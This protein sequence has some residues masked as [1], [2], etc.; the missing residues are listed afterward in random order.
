MRKLSIAVLFALMFAGALV[1][2]DA[3][4]SLVWNDAEG[5]QSVVTVDTYVDLQI[6][7]E[8]IDSVPV[9]QD[10]KVV[11]H[12]SF[13]QVV[14]KVDGD[15][16]A[17][18]LALECT[19]CTHEQNGGSNPTEG[20]VDTAAAGQS[21]TVI[22]DGQSYQVDVQSDAMLGLEDTAGIGEWLELRH[23]LPKNDVK[24]NDQWNVEPSLLVELFL[25]QFTATENNVV[26][27]LKNVDADVAVIRV[28]GEFSGEFDALKAT[29]T[30]TGEFHF[31]IKTGAPVKFSTSNV[32]LEAEGDLVQDGAAL[33]KVKASAKKIDVTM[34]FVPG[35][36]E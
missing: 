12:Q 29:A 32:L 35:A 10:V 36:G 23:L 11:R 2:Q 1:A 21:L 17:S 33:G 5:D 3:S 22:R 24:V 26:C 30:L 13:S 20:V 6:R 8:D 28:H 16:I 34:T 14:E 25:Q 31:N 9:K 7:A 4:Y 27:T 19:S 18:R 15:N